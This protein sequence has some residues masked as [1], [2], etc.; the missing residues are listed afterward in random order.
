MTKLQQK[1]LSRLTV[2]DIE[3]SDEL[4]QSCMEMSDEMEN[5]R[6][7]GERSLLSLEEL[8]RSNGIFWKLQ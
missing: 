4:V 2:S 8:A 1:Y 3:V 7:S 5:A 6:I